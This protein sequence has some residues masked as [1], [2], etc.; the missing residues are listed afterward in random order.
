MELKE[1][2]DRC[3]NEFFDKN[4]TIRRNTML[5]SIITPSV[6]IVLDVI[7]FVS[8]LD[9]AEQDWQFFVIVILCLLV[10]FVVYFVL[11]QILFGKSTALPDSVIEKA[12]ADNSY[13]NYPKDYPYSIVY[14]GELYPFDRVYIKPLAAPAA[15]PSTQSAPT[16]T[17]VP[18]SQQSII[19]CE[20]CGQPM[21]IPVTDGAVKITC[22]KCGKSFIHTN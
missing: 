18:A 16:P 2:Q 3:Y 11:F 9:V 15:A 10:P 21:I 22:P 17:E 19:T 14:P 1:F 13:M 20:Q 6:L 7:A 4:P 12:K 8:L 5:Y